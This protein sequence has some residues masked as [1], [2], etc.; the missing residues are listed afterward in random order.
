MT[1][2]QKH[3]DTHTKDKKTKQSKDRK[4]DEQKDKKIKRQASKPLGKTGEELYPSD[5]AQPLILYA[6]SRS[7]AR[8]NETKLF[9][10]SPTSNFHGHFYFHFRIWTVSLP[11]QRMLGEKFQKISRKF[12][13]LKI[14][15]LP[16]ISGNSWESAFEP[17]EQEV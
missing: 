6:C 2:R 12:R 3:K 10:G 4:T 1:K 7:R 8:I 9:P 15:E 16:R 11:I 14:F 13:E 17:V 5:R